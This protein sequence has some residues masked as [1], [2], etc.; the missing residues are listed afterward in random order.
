MQDLQ[1]LSRREFCIEVIL[2]LYSEIPA[3][4]FAISVILLPCSRNDVVRTDAPPMVAGVSCAD[5][6]RNSAHSAK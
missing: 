3:T 2:S 6:V 5:A 1:S 4:F